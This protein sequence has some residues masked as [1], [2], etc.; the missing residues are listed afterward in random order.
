M[1][2]AKDEQIPNID[3]FRGLTAGVYVSVA[4]GGSTQ[5]VCLSNYGVVICVEKE[6]YDLN[7]IWRFQ[8]AFSTY[9]QLFLRYN[10]NNAGWGEW[11]EL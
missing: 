2:I 6:G 5:G 4:S 8:L 3:E 7:F 1:R 11:K 9:G 10:I